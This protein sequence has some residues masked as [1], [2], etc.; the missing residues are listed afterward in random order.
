MPQKCINSKQRFRNKIIY[1]LCLGNISKD[2]TSDNLGKK[3]LNG[4]VFDFSVDYNI[5]N[6]NNSLDIHK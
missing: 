4:Y 2:F 1:S 5:I 3:V 6:T